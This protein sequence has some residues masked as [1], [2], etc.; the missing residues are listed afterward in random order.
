MLDGQFGLGLAASDE[1]DCGEGSLPDGDV[2]VQ[3][4]GKLF[5]VGKLAQDRLKQESIFSSP[6]E[7]ISSLLPF[8]FGLT[9]SLCFP[10]GFLGVTPLMTSSSSSSWLFLFFSLTTGLTALAL[11]LFPCM[12]RLDASSP[13]SLRA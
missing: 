13:T 3:N 8:L 10:C 5:Q 7:A 2:H 9:S 11:A 12:T 1:V 6:L 4:G